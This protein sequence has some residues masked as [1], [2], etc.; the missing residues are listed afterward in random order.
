MWSS[1]S[2]PHPCRPCTGPVVPV[3]AGC[4]EPVWLLTLPLGQC[5]WPTSAVSLVPP[6]FAKAVR[7]VNKK[8]V[9]GAHG[10]SPQTRLCRLAHRIKR[11]RLVP[12]DGQCTHHPRNNSLAR[13]GWN[14]LKRFSKGI[15]ARACVWLP[16]KGSWMPRTC[17]RKIRTTALVSSRMA[18][19]TKRRRRR[20]VS[21]T[22]WARGTHYPRSLCQTLGRMWVPPSQH[23]H[24]A[25]N[26]EL[27]SQ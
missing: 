20:G 11:R 6:V 9:T 2:A 12:D 26:D 21:L 4:S 16:G 24:H 3:A 14:N 5:Y 10:G 25:I 8:S 15:C 18:K 22:P 17:M 19:L 23:A 1:A 7:R 13:R 27:L